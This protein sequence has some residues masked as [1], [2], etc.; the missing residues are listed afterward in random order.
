MRV[1]IN[2]L[3]ISIDKEQNSEILKELEK[4]GINKENIKNLKYLKRS[5][6]SRKK[7]DIK[8]IYSLEIE[9]KEKINLE[10]YKKLSL[11]KEIFL[12]KR[13]PIYPKREVAV[14]GAGPAGLFSA[15]RLAEYGYIPIV[16]E[17]GEEVEKRNKTTAEFIRTYKLNPNSN[18]QFGEGGA[19]TYSDGK[20]NTGIR[21]EYIDKIFN[22]LVSCGAQEEILWN[23][24]PH[25]GTDVLRIVVKN[26]R[27]KIKSMGGKFYFNS[28]VKDIKIEN[29]S[30]KSLI[31]QENNNKEYEYEIDK[32]I[33]AIGHSARD[34]YNILYQRG[35]AMENKPF[36]IGLR[37]EHLRRD[38]DKMQY[39]KNISN[40]NLEAATY[41]MAYNNKNETRGIFSF[42]MCP[43]GEIV[44][45]SSESGASLVNGMSY[46]TRNGKFSNSAIVV[47]ISEKDYGDQIFSGMKLQ[48][49]LEKKN[50]E[51]V[52]TYGAIYQNVIDFMKNIV[53]KESI[54]SSY[55][56]KLTAYDMNNFFPE[57]IT[58]NL[59]AAFENWSKN[60]LFISKN[61]NLIGPETRTSAPVKILRDL[62]GESLSIK[63]IFPIGEGA[64]YAGG[65]TSAAVDGIRVVD[66]AFSK[67][68]D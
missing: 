53:T 60:N 66:L 13:L 4:N 28:Q 12:K 6:D 35:L 11:A 47:G 8:F 36:A 31:I 64:G 50:Y 33:F 3:I 19:G 25:I 51:I 58:R 42:C 55:K 32:A 2:N 45:A 44:N 38:I 14:I 68:I 49:K 40:P 15:L 17:R 54:E 34:T 9:L 27:E 65:I 22:E 56:M 48:E 61:V 46:S 5:I 43:G 37:I 63:G 52:G 67:I 59:R 62:K 30:L 41:N 26:L 7:N 29:K 21:S 16:F 57:Y 18:I 20:L 39:G 1:N 23:Y 24:K 10:K